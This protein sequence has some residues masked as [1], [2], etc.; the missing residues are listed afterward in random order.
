[1]VYPRNSHEVSAL[2]IYYFDNFANLSRINYENFHFIFLE[3]T[4]M[5]SLLLEYN[6]ST[7][8]NKSQWMNGN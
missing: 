1:M 2:V 8:I 6:I 3:I 4:L 7:S 5:V